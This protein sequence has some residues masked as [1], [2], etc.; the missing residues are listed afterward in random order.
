MTMLEKAA[1]AICAADVKARGASVDEMWPA[2]SF[3]YLEMARAALLAIRRPDA[4]AC[5]AAERA[6]GISKVLANQSFTAMID[7]ILSEAGE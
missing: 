4:N 1:R 7:A 2:L 3:A 5:E 6:T